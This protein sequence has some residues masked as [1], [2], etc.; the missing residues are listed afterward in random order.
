MNVNLKDDQMKKA[1][2]ITVIVIAVL[3]LFNGFINIVDNGR[4]LAYDITSILSGIG[5]LLLN[6]G[7]I[8]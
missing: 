1:V 2:N 3:L 7:K 8:R 4:V 6:A 5:L